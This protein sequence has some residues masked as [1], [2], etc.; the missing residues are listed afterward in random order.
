MAARK[1]TT[2]APAYPAPRR[3][4][5]TSRQN[6]TTAP[7]SKASPDLTL[8]PHLAAATPRSAPTKASPVDP[9]VE[10]RMKGAA[11]AKSFAAWKAQQG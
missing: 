10:A 11:S 7:G 8:P 5:T 9:Q 6:T 3:K 1:S 2:K 4:P